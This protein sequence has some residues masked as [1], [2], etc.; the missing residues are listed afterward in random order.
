MSTVSAIHPTAFVDPSAVLGEGTT[1]GPF[2][3]VSA[4]VRVGSGCEIRTHAVLEGPGTVIGDRNR[5][6]AGCVVGGPPQDK[7]YDGEETELVVGDENIFREHVTVNRGTP[8]GGGITRIGD[9]NLLLAGSHV[10]HDCELGNDIILSNDVLLAGH[11]VVEDFAIMSGASAIHQF[12][13]VGRSA[14]VGG[15]TR[16][17]RDAP[18]YMVVEG[19]PARTVKV[20]AI[21]LQRRGVPQERIEILQRAYRYL[22]RGRH[23]TL[24]ESFA[25]LDRDGLTSPELEHLRAFLKRMREGRG[26]RGR[27]RSWVSAASGATTRASSARSTRR[28]WLRS[29]TWTRRVTTSS[30]SAMA[31]RYWPRPTSC[32]RTSRPSRSRCPPSTTRTWPFR[33]SDAASRP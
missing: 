15:L 31:Y 12:G 9:R 18:P 33:C 16:L 27:E 7:K 6:F 8:G 28:S 13:T 19:H 22:F 2:A 1:V 4:G 26:G 29:W 24:Q 20:N 32:P 17:V 11:V 5:F 25:A 21:G 3:V 30:P 14:Y 23:A 10:A